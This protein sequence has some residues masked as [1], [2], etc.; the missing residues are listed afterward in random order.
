MSPGKPRCAQSW[1]TPQAHS[2]VSTASST[3]PAIYETGKRPEDVTDAEWDRTI[4]V[5]LDRDIP[6]LPRHPAGC[7]RQA[8]AAS[9]TSPRCMRWRPFPACRPMPRQGGGAGAV[10][11][12]RA[13]LCRR[14]H[15]RERPGR[16]LGRHAH[17]ARR[18]RSAGGAEALGLSST[19]T[20]CPHRR[21]HEIATAIAFL[22]SDAS[23]F[24]TGVPSWSMAA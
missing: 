17:D 19:G 12:A 15:P 18:P 20:H 10:A 11:P 8:A 22:L 23:S 3:P 9:S 2:K 4:A 1:R 13:R 16:R 7:A 14:P 6:G 24:V 21:P 5:N